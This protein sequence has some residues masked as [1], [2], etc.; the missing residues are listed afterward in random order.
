MMLSYPVL[1]YSS[2]LFD[3]HRTQLVTDQFHGALL[4]GL[5][6]YYDYYF[7]YYYYYEYCSYYYYDYNYCD[8]YHKELLLLLLLSLH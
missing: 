5:R 1:A 4:E 8:T 3:G 6:G 7:Y 2:K